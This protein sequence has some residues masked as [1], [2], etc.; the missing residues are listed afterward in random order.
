MGVWDSRSVESRIGLED[1]FGIENVQN[2]FI[3][4]KSYR[5]KKHFTGYTL[6]K[7]LWY[8]YVT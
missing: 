6:I 1:K 2:C 3:K 4:K 8:K 7:H 5:Q